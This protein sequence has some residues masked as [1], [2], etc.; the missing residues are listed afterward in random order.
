MP[1]RWGVPPVR[2]GWTETALSI[3]VSP[4]CILIML[5]CVAF[6]LVLLQY[7]RHERCLYAMGSNRIAAAYSGISIKTY[8]LLAGM[9]TAAMI[10]VGAIVVCSHNF[11]KTA[12]DLCGDGL[13]SDYLQEGFYS[14]FMRRSFCV[15]V[16]R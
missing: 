12:A 4:W 14:L 8:R 6:A 10:S 1:M 13:R 9:L 11:G 16:L 7:T 3:G 15:S 5:A 2:T